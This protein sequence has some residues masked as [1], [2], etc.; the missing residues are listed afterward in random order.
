MLKGKHYGKVENQN[1]IKGLGVPGESTFNFKYDGQV[2][3]IVKMTVE[4]IFERFE[5]YSHMI[6]KERCISGRRTRL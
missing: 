2:K 4:Q 6:I 3:V 1:M 5:D